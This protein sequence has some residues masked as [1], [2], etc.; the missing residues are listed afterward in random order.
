MC[1]NGEPVGEFDPGYESGSEITF[2]CIVGAGGVR[3]TWKIICDNGSWIGRSQ[4]CGK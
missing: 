3:T 4:D 2:N 1:R